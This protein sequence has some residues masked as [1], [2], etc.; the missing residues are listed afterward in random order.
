MPVVYR[1]D[2]ESNESAQEWYGMSSKGEETSCRVTEMVKYN[3]LRLSD[4]LKGM[5][6]SENFAQ[7]FID[8]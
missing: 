3:T 7:L 2:T 5:G 4:H 6:E 1:V 8:A